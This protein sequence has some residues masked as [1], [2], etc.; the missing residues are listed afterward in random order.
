MEKS[1]EE[2][3]KNNIEKMEGK[4]IEVLQEGFINSSTKLQ[5]INYKIK[6][7][8]LSIESEDGYIRINLNQ[9]YKV[10]NRQNRLKLFLDNDTNI[11]LKYLN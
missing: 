8:I 7:D 5:N 4:Q 2:Q 11:I 9:V 3:I 10:V 6:R 1:T